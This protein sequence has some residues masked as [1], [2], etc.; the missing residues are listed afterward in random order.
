MITMPPTSQQPIPIVLD[1]D[2]GTDIDDVYALILA[3]VS[4]EFD[5]RA[6]TTVNND[7]VLRAK[8]ARRVLNLL[9]RPDI[10]VVVGAGDSLTPDEH[11]G[12]MGHEGLGL[13]LPD[14]PEPLS[15]SSEFDAPADA[16]ACIARCAEI[17]AA[18]G[19][20]LTVFTIGA[21]TN[22]A[23]AL[24]DYPESAH[25]I[26][27]VIAMA[28]TFE[29]FGE[30]LAQPEHNICCDPV[31]ADIVLCSG[32]P[33]TLIGLN[34]TRE[35]TMTAAE[36]DTLK[37]IGGPLAE[38][39]VGM[40]HIWFTAIKRDNSPMHDGLAVALPLDP[41][42]VTLIP[43]DAR[44]ET[45]GPRRGYTICQQP[46]GATSNCLFANSVDAAR[47]HALLFSRVHEAVKQA[48]QQ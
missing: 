6:V 39:L 43:V 4:P 24:R 23:L 31:A 28:S 27:Q 7:V 33:L 13:T 14:E 18:T 46:E 44:V 29:G 34:V 38:G 17:A 21:M 12:W 3:A 48:T 1:T 20:P 2:I 36:V 16:A 32:L 9:G 11:R 45:S 41:S 10:P 26:G 40:H 15:V 22:L 8:I 25:K 30:D 37:A 5:L 19:T 42:L 47:F 35:T